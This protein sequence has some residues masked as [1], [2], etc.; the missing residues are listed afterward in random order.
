M[1]Q[2]DRPT[3]Q[4]ILGVHRGLLSVD[5]PF[6]NPGNQAVSPLAQTRGGQM[7]YADSP[8]P[9]GSVQHTKPQFLAE[10]MPD[11]LAESR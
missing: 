9:V 8:L 3:G 7:S 2:Q 11:L 6:V 10:S 4:L 5:V 1:V